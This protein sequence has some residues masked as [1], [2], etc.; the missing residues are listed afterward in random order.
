MKRFSVLLTF[1]NSCQEKVLALLDSKT[2]TE[3]KKKHADE[4]HL[5]YLLEEKHR[6]WRKL[7]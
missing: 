7:K 2:C 1:S 6:V 4:D 3:S 5:P